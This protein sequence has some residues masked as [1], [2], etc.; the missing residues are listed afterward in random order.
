L[1]EMNL[2]IPWAQLLALIMNRP[3]Y[4]GGQLV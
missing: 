1:D 3:G 4:R 2:V